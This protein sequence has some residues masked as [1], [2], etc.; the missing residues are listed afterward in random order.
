MRHVKLY[1]YFRS[2]AAY[3]CRIAFNLKGV[4]P[5]YVPIHLRRGDQRAEDYLRLNPQGLVPA[6]DIGSRVLTQSLA[7]IEWLDETHPEP[8]LLPGDAAERADIRAFA[9]AI[10]ADIHPLNNLR[11]L[12]YLKAP[13]GHDQATID[14]WYRHWVESGLAACEALVTK[15]GRRGPYCFGAEPTLADICLIPQLANARRV[16]S[17]LAEKEDCAAIVRAVAGLGASLGI[18]TTAEGVETVEQLA[19]VRAQGCTEAQGYLFSRPRRACDLPAVFAEQAARG[20]ARS[21]A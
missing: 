14:A 8:A 9:L 3:R 6:L 21:A 4:A 16:D 5:E 15:E 13:L 11:V 10:A 12:K 7:I 20:A 1:G 18:T 19:L 17:D 2:S